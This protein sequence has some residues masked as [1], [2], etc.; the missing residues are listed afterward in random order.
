MF[1]INSSFFDK[2]A[3]MNFS[4]VARNFSPLTYQA[5]VSFSFELIV[6]N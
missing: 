4:V 1:K 2:L 3:T 6:T 5:F